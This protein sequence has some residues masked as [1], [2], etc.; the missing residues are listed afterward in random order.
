MS[1]ILES[2]ASVDHA[3]LMK[4]HLYRLSPILIGLFNILQDTNFAPVATRGK[5][6]SSHSPAALKLIILC[7]QLEK[8]AN[9]TYREEID[10]REYK[11][12][13]SKIIR[14]PKAI[15]SSKQNKKSRLARS[16]FWN[17][18]NPLPASFDTQDCPK[19]FHPYIQ[20]DQTQKNCS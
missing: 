17:P 2:V 1:E 7:S 11:Y 18:E 3:T 10:K 13:K 16:R 5:P 6:K 14:K 15:G 19:C 9:E 4:W 20:F 12:Q 8:L